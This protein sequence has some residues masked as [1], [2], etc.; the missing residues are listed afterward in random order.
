MRTFSS[1]AAPSDPAT[2][3]LSTVEVF[4]RRSLSHLRSIALGRQ[5]GSL[6]WLTRRDGAW[7]ACLANYDGKGGEPGRD[8]RATLLVKFD[9]DWRRFHVWR[10][11]PTVLARLAPKSASGGVWGE[12]GLLYVTGHDA[13][14]I[15]VLRAP[16]DGDWHALGQM[17]VI[18]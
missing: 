9:D 5:G 10:F 16:P 3:M 17:H 15:Y 12:G 4:D 14:E 13:P 18:E 11:P 2:P 7:W 6:T 8:H 1:E